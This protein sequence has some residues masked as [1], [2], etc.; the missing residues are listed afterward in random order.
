[1]TKCELVSFLVDRQGFERSLTL[2]GN[3]SVFTADGE[4]LAKDLVPTDTLL[5]P[6]WGQ[7]DRCK[8]KVVFGGQFCD[9]GCAVSFRNERELSLGTH[10]SQQPDWKAK[11]YKRMGQN[12]VSNIEDVVA[13]LI[14]SQGGTTCYLGDGDADWI[15]QFRVPSTKD[16]KGRQHYYF[17]DFYNPKLNLALEVD[18]HFHFTSVGLDRDVQRDRRLADQGIA[19]V[20]V[21]VSA[22][23][24]GEFERQ[25]LPSLLANHEADIELIHTGIQQLRK[26]SATRSYPMDRRWDITVAEGA[27]Y[28][29]NGVLI[30]NS[31]HDM[32]EQ[33]LA[34]PKAKRAKD[35]STYL[36]VPFDHSPGS[37]TSNTPASSMPM[38]DAVRKEMKKR[39][40]PWGKVERDDQGRPLLGRLHRFDVKQP[41]KTGYGPGQGHGPVGD[42]RQGMNQRQR[43]GGGPGGGGTP[44]L[45][46]VHV[47]QHQEGQGVKRS[48][49]TYRI[50]SSK[51]QGQGMWRH[52][53]LDPV[54]IIDDTAEWCLDQ[55]DRVIVPALLDRVATLI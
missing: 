9:G 23:R 19:T 31:P 34:S 15:R 2:T 46:G 13:K 35:G 54:R 44:F 25:I 36:V 32:L 26:F 3:H 40:I 49:V 52:P 22:I 20:R 7:C 45:Q 43:A 11:F 42:V 27:S 28:V 33:L 6:A 12:K 4:V 38:V 37:S 5:S 50:A 21:P 51:Q 10:V 48:V 18:G 8:K 14:E 17:I 16:A 53:G 1:M 29:C 55:V 39:K 47:Y 30:H 24:S 41:E